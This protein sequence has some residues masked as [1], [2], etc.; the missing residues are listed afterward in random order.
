MELMR[1]DG[2]FIALWPKE[3]FGMLSAKEPLMRMIPIPLSP[4]G[5][6]IAAMVSCSDIKAFLLN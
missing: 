6:A 2:R 5:V 4:K 3:A 1:N